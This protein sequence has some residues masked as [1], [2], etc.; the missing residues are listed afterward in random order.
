MGLV[1]LFNKD[2]KAFLRWGLLCGLSLVCS[3]LTIAE[4]P[5]SPASMETRSQASRSLISEPKFLNQRTPSRWQGMYFGTGFRF[6]RFHL[7]DQIVENKNI[8]NNGVAFNLGLLWRDKVLEYSRHA[9]I[10]DSDQ[11]LIYKGKVFNGIEV[12]QNNFWIFKAPRVYRDVYFYYGTGLQFAQIR[13]LGGEDLIEESSFV[14]GVGGTY[15]VTDY[16]LL[17]YRLNHSF[18]SPLLTQTRNQPAMAESQLHTLYWEYYF[19]F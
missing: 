14:I 9:S 7:L 11:T 16:L 17:Q 2:H 3:T 4:T 12:I 18:Y 8:D 19:A 15:F 10:V 13:F 6:L 5:P 1:S